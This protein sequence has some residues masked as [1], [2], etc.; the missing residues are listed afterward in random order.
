MACAPVCAERMPGPKKRTRRQAGY[1]R[2]IPP[3]PR[4]GGGRRERSASTPAA[5]ARRRRRERSAFVMKKTYTFLQVGVPS[6]QKSC[7]LAVPQPKINWQAIIPVLFLARFL[8]TI[9]QWCRDQPPRS[10]K[11]DHG[12]SSHSPRENTFDKVPLGIG[13]S[14]RLP[15]SSFG[16]THCPL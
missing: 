11:S 2:R 15:V 6:Q 4:Q 13:F 16:P 9:I 12:S 3:P 14:P 8:N 7:P 5:T 1:T 10:A